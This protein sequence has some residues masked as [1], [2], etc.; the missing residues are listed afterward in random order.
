MS[1]Y[2]EGASAPNLKNAATPRFGHSD[3]VFDLFIETCILHLITL[4]SKF[5]IH[6][7]FPG[8][9]GPNNLALCQKYHK[10]RLLSIS[11]DG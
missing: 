2:P 5:S 9:A 3:V 7:N 11:A 6:F 4:L 10:F 1:R 8:I